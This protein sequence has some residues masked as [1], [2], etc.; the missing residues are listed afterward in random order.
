MKCPY[1]DSNNRDDA[2]F[3]EMCE[4]P[5]NIVSERKIITRTTL[6]QSSYD[7][8][9]IYTAPNI[10][11]E[12]T[13]YVSCPHC[14]CPLSECTPIVKTTVTSTGG[15]YGFFS[16]CCGAMLLGPLGLLCGLRGRDTTSTSQTWWACRNC[17]KEFV[18]AGAAKE[19]ADS[20][21]VSS[22]VMT[23]VI[24]IIWQVVH[25]FLGYSSWIRNIALL[26]IAGTWMVLP[27]QV[28]EAT[29]YTV[30]QLMVHEE[31]VGFYKKCAFYGVIAFFIGSAVGGKG[32][33]FLLS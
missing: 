20:V 2:A 9:P 7:K 23:G 27:E 1:C 13:T 4:M 25:A 11:E 15:G 22:A 3:C 12:P 26:A 10:R 18:E 29:G 16:G 17:G 19:I 30:R 24:A 14:G 6:P 21:L 8:Q 33:E 5:L 31:R 28:K 32:M